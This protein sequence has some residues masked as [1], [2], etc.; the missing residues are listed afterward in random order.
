MKLKKGI[1][2]SLIPL[3]VLLLFFLCFSAKIVVPAWLQ[4]TGRMH[5]LLL[6]FPIVIVLLYVGW[7]LL[8]P[9]ALKASTW[10]AG[11]EETLLLSAAFTTAITALSGFLLS[12]EEGYEDAIVDW[13]KW[14]G[15]TLSFLLFI[16]YSYR[17]KITKP[18]LV[19]TTLLAITVIVIWAAHLGGNI[20][21][22]QNFVLAPITPEKQKPSA[23]LEEAIVYADVIEPILQNKCMSCHNNGKAKGELIMETKEALL[24]G[25][26]NGV[27]WDTASADL[28]LL[29]Q[30][31]HLPEEAKKHMPPVGKPQLTAFEINLLKA[32]ISGG[33]QFE[34]KV[35]ELPES[36]TLRSLATT[37]LRS[38]EEDTYTFEPAADKQIQQL[39]N[40]NRV[41]TPVS[42]GS[43]AL[44]VNFYNRAFY[45]AKEL[46]ALK[47]V[48]SQIV[49]L[50]LD[51]MPVKDPD[52]NIIA[53]FKNLRRLN[54]NFTDITGSTLQEL[55]KLK[56]LK[57]LSLTGTTVNAAQ[58]QA[59]QKN[60][61]LKA[62]Y[63]WNTG[64]TEQQM[65][66]LQQAAPNIK[67]YA[68]FKDTTTLQIIPPVI[69]NEE[70]VITQPVALKLKHYIKGTEI[71]YT[72]DGK[73]PDS[74]SSPVYN[75]EILLKE[76]GLV[77]AKA[78]KKGWVAS[79][80][81]Q[82]Q[83]YRSAWKVDSAIL[84]TDPDPKYRAR[85]AATIIDR[86]KA[87]PN[88]G[89]GKWIGYHGKPITATLLFSKPAMVSSV[90]I[91]MV[92]SVNEHVF[93]PASIQ[94]WGG[95]DKDHLTLLNTLRPPAPAK[96]DRGKMPIT[97]DSRFAPA[98]LSCIKLV[99][100][101]IPNIKPWIADKGAQSWLFIDEVF[102]N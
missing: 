20:T 25:G 22:G 56:E 83:F 14:I 35:L 11:I 72:L 32:W 70:L 37:L 46:E 12:K 39:G 19:N 48:E 90:T 50:N 78:Y 98:E 71:R 16:L 75:K 93:P 68:G 89:N 51:K 26:K 7:V 10:Y 81:A 45:A 80:V 88:Y 36:D 43:P 6:H 47:P 34:K 1:A 59:L 94:V 55:S 87:E 41:I 30:R 60:K 96:D 91:S 85:G 18:V 73:E 100:T 42:A 17:P 8:S 29:M 74:I 31:I 77:K 54:L 3:N 44:T 5:P 86:E 15:A 33:A 69:E 23:P 67:Y 64:I 2:V 82:K 28:G 66:V 92:K 40:N 99:L 57:L 49:D 65:A 63:C 84:A 101:P 38:S 97:F 52:L 21:H 53:R 4:V 24:K 27:L 79:E 13:H 62:V 58:L 95:K 61:N 102:I 76:T 9:R